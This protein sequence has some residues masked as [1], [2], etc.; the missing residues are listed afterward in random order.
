[1]RPSL[2]G[3]RPSL[4]SLVVNYDSRCNGSNGR[5]LARMDKEQFHSLLSPVVGCPILEKNV[6]EP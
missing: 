3:M 1:M 2:D 6:E 5:Y 4:F